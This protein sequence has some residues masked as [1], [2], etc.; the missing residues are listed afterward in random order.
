MVYSFLKDSEGERFWK[1]KDSEMYK[2]QAYSDT[3]FSLMWK[4]NEI[5]EIWEFSLIYRN[6]KIFKIVSAVVKMLQQKKHL[7]PT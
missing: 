4:Q 3:H 1:G 6:Q 7:T 2:K 5:L